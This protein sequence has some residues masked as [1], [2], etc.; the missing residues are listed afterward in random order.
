MGAFF[1]SYNSIKE[2][3]FK[4][5]SLDFNTPTINKNTL[6]ELMID[7]D[8]FGN[9]PIE[10]FT[11]N[12]EIPFLDIGIP[13]SYKKSQEYIPKIISEMKFNG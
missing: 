8:C 7:R 11:L 12:N 1:I 3:W 13:S 2:R 5:T 10:G 9:Y 6:G 4:K